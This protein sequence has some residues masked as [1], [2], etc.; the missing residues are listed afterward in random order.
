MS[1]AARAGQW[2]AAHWKTATFGWLAFV[3]C[4]VAIGSSSGTVK[5]MG[6]EQPIGESA[7]AQAMLNRG[8]FQNRAGEN[9]LIQ[10]RSLPAADPGFRAEVA[11]V[12]HRRV[13]AVLAYPER[14]E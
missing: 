7:R 11:E 6:F 2:S 9:V 8:G 4:A 3:I 10:S 14:A 13:L 1:I 12:D 5:L